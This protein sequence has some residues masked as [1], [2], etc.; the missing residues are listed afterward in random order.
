MIELF[1]N[2]SGQN[3]I[4]LLGFEPATPLDIEAAW[5]EQ[6]KGKTFTGAE[7]RDIL[8]G[9]QACLVDDRKKV[10]RI[11]PEKLSGKCKRYFGYIRANMIIEEAIKRVEKLICPDEK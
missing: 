8:I 11:Y 2:T 5:R 7:V 10:N 4:E 3:N 6:N 1:K 9:L